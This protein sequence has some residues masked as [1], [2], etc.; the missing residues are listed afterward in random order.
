AG[1]Y[2]VRDGNGRGSGLVGVPPGGGSARGDRWLGLRRLAARRVAAVALDPS[3]TSYKP[4]QNTKRSSCARPERP[5]AHRGDPSAGRGPERRSGGGSSNPA[6]GLRPD[7]L[8][9]L[10]PSVRDPGRQ[11]VPL[12]PRFPTPS[13]V[14]LPAHPR[15]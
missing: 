4:W 15:L 10:L 8:P 14:R 5:R 12:Q 11:V 2:R 3:E 9:T 6:P 7:A 1:G 13:P